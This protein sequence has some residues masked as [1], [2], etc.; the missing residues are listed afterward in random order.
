MGSLKDFKQFKHQNLE[1]NKTTTMAKKAIMNEKAE[2]KAF[3]SESEESDIEI[4]DIANCNEDDSASDENYSTKLRLRKSRELNKLNDNTILPNRLRSD[5]GKVYS[6]SVT[7]DA[8]TTSSATIHNLKQADLDTVQEEV[9]A[10]C[11]NVLSSNQNMKPCSAGACCQNTTKLL[12][13]MTKLQTT[14]DTVVSQVS[15]QAAVNAETELKLQAVQEK[16]EE[17]EGDIESLTKELQ[18]CKFQL[19]TVSKIIVRQEEQISFLNR[20]VTE[21]QQREMNPNIVITGIPEKKGEKALMCFN[22]FVVNQLE[23][24]ELIP[25]LQAFRIG[26]GPNRPLI[27]ELRD[28]RNH[29]KKIFAQAKKLKGKTNQE[30]KPYFIADHLPEELHENRRRMNDLV[31]ENRKKPVGYKLEMEFKN[32]KLLINDELYE[33]QIKA[34]SA[35]ELIFPSER[36]MDIAAEIDLVKGK[37]AEEGKSKFVAFAAAVNEQL[38]IHAAYLKLKMKYANATHIACAYRLPGANTPHQQDY[39]D[40]GEFGCGRILLKALK[41]EQLMNVA[42][43][44]VR[45]YGGKHIGPT[46]FELFRQVAKSAIKALMTKRHKEDA[47]TAVE[48][49]PENLKFPNQPDLGAPQESWDSKE[50]TA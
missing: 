34:P 48:T 38:D 35:E 40:D 20:K 24:Q 23:L 28:P 50:F 12:E 11:A 46:R 37:G 43:F 19:N 36:I 3:S 33:K 30:G 21:I 32:G 39:F 2:M 17:N 41:D 1:G 13:M 44:M 42:V 7:V 22:D 25:A 29:K 4:N 31:S 5:S 45:I 6:T 15:G 8:T 10:E 26:N 14:M 16:C 47:K 27:V 9:E 18:D 49:L